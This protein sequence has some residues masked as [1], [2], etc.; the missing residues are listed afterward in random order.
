MVFFLGNWCTDAIQC[1]CW[2]LQPSSR[3]GLVLAFRLQLKKTLLFLSGFVVWIFFFLIPGFLSS[4]PL[5]FLTGCLAKAGWCC[6]LQTLHQATFVRKPVQGPF[7]GTPSW[8]LEV[9]DSVKTKE[10]ELSVSGCLFFGSRGWVFSG[11]P[12]SLFFSA[13]FFVTI[14]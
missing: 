7:V 3:K 9:M 13:F 10:A 2:E 14:V 6:E 4:N 8:R 12:F 11:F 1:P 5:F